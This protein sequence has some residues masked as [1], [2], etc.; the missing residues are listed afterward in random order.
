MKQSRIE[1]FIP[2]FFD[3]AAFALMRQR[4]ETLLSGRYRL[5]FHLLDDSAGLDT[6]LAALAGSNTL[7]HVLP[8]RM[9]HQ[10]ALVFGLKNYL[11]AG[12][13]YWVVTMDADGEDRPE[14][15]LQLLQQ[16]EKEEN[17]F[18]LAKRTE[19]KESLSFK[20]MYFF[21]KRL[22]RL[23]TGLI[24]ESGNFAV[25]SP[26]AIRAILPFLGF[27]FVYSSSL[28]AYGRPLLFVPCPKGN[29]LAGESKMDVLRLIR[30]G[31]IMLIPFWPL[32]LLRIT[33]VLALVFF[34]ISLRI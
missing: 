33:V 15:L 9:G 14:D 18:V 32:I 21:Y 7:I 28:L 27:R 1:I 22:F 26:D 5:Q 30:H 34:V 23:L 20:V 24:V 6:S 13:D 16:K 31:L 25:Y 3:S 19:R 2:I 29:R 8:R 12:S 4:M 11:P 10:A 17:A